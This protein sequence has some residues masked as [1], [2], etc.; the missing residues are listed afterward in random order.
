M[1]QIFDEIQ[2][3]VLNWDRKGREPELEISSDESL[4]EEDLVELSP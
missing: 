2:A 3:E 1:E 4:S